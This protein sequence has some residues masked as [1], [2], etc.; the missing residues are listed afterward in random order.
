MWG[1]GTP[2]SLTYEAWFYPVAVQVWDNATQRLYGLNAA[3][4]SSRTTSYADM[5]AALR[6]RGRTRIPLAGPLAVTVPGAVSGW[7]ALHDRFGVLPWP[8]LFE[9]AVRYARDGFPVSPVIAHAWARHLTPNSS[10]VTS[11]GRHVP[12]GSAPGGS[13]HGWGGGGGRAGAQ[14]R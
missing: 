2:P 11:G 9:A 5:Q 8:Q 14:Q 3:G 6:A 7:C 4:R 13:Y 1:W 12:R 10:D